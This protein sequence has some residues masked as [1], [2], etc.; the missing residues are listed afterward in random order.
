M[1]KF[2]ITKTI[3]QIVVIEVEEE[4]FETVNEKLYDGDYE[5]EF[6]SEEYEEASERDSDYEIIELEED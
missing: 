2:Q 4:D 6:L 5:D 1:P 3:T